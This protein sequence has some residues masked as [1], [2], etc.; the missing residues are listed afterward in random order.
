MKHSKK[1]YRQLQYCDFGILST[2]WECDCTSFSPG[3]LISC[4]EKN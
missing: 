2:G 3:S 4:A 1:S